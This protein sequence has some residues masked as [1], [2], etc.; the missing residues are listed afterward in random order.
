[1]ATAIFAEMKKNM[2]R[3]QTKYRVTVD[4]AFQ[5]LRPQNFEDVGSKYASDF[6]KAPEKLNEIKKYIFSGFKKSCYHLAKFDSDSE[7]LMSELLE[8]DASVKLWMKPGPNQFKLY[9]SDGLPYQPDFVA[10]SNDRLLII[11]TKR[12]DQM[13]EASVLQ[14]AELAALWAHIATVC[15]SQKVGGKPWTYLL[16]PHTAVAPNTTLS[17]LIASFTCQADA[18]LL[19]RYELS[20]ELNLSQQA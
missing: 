11:E 19:T 14:K 6:R 20:N 7:R 13:K 18:E 15:H 3:G 12:A 4:A 1:M 5:D 8:R 17:G 16:V 9:S 10:E 2:W